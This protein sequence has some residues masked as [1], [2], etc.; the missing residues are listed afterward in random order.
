MA[1]QIPGDRLI[2]TKDGDTP[3]KKLWERKHNQDYTEYYTISDLIYTILGG[4]GGDAGSLAEDI[5]MTNSDGA[6][7]HLPAI[8]N[9]TVGSTV[10]PAG[11]SIEGLLREI[12]NPYIKTT[13]SINL[14][15]VAFEVDGTWGDFSDYNEDDFTLEVGQGFKLYSLNYSIANSSVTVDDSVSFHRNN[16]S[17]L[18]DGISTTGGTFQLPTINVYNNESVGYNGYTESFHLEAVDNGSGSNLPIISNY[19]S[20]K[21]R[22]RIRAG[23]SAEASANTN[24]IEALFGELDTYNALVTKSSFSFQGDAD[25]TD[26]TKFLWIAYPA[27]WGAVYDIEVSN[28]GVLPDFYDPVVVSRT[29]TH[30]ASVSYLLYK[31]KSKGGFGVGQPINVSFA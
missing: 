6:F 4:E 28:T 16:N 31:S 5:I 7:V 15:N 26:D 20:F 25:T 11:T 17:A 1:T 12:L 27:S 21:F 18:Y 2:N 14:V 29:N 22:D 9:E 3:D 8:Y 19:I 10:I 24:N 13:M 23:G 30:G